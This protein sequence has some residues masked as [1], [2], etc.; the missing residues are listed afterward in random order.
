MPLP[1]MTCVFLM[2]P[3][4]ADGFLQLLTRYESTNL[5]RLFT[6]ALFGLGLYALAAQSILGTVRWGYQI[7]VMIRNGYLPGVG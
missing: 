4:I 3:M 5:R 7:G 2:L 6:G 1:I